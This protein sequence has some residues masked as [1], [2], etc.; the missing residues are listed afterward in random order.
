MPVCLVRLVASL[1]V[2]ARADIAYLEKMKDIARTMRYL[3]LPEDLKSRV[4]RYHEYV[5]NVFGT[6]DTNKLKTFADKL[7]RP[8]SAEVKLHCHTNLIK[9]VPLFDKLDHHISRYLI[10]CLTVEIYMPGDY[11]ISRASSIRDYT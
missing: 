9:N 11:V 4:I 3:Q 10:D 7:S 6:F 2:T 5:H 1:Q 8:L